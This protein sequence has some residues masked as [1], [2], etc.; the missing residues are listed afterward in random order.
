VQ[1]SKKQQTAL[2]TLSIKRACLIRPS[3]RRKLRPCKL[4]DRDRTRREHP[5]RFDARFGHS[6]QRGIPRNGKGV[7]VDLADH[8]ENYRHARPEEI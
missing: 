6:R 8:R 1:F 4:Y 3:M 7:P 2:S 5:E